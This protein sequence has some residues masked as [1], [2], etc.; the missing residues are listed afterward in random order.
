MM[1]GG[2][3]VMRVTVCV[4]KVKAYY[5]HVRIFDGRYFWAYG[6]CTVVRLDTQAVQNVWV[7]FAYRYPA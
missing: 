5:R 2:L 7:H 1:R 3:D 4:N 6:C